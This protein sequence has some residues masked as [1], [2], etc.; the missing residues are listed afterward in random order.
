MVFAPQALKMEK[1]SLSVGPRV[2]TLDLGILF[3]C[4]DGPQ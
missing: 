4:F 3:S 1:S 2:E